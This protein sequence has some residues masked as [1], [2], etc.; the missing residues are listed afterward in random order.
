MVFPTFASA[1]ESAEE[2][3]EILSWWNEYGKYWQAAE[4]D[5]DDESLSMV[6]NNTSS[7]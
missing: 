5:A 4:A 2:V 6:L 7:E 3:E 1:E